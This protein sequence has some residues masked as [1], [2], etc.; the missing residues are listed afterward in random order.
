[1][2][3][4]L[5]QI[6]NKAGLKLAIALLRDPDREVRRLAI[7]AVGRIGGLEVSGLVTPY[8]DDQ[9]LDVREQ[10]A[11]ALALMKDR[12]TTE[13]LITKAKLQDPAQ[14]SYVYALYRLADER[15]IPVMHEIL[16]NPSASPS[17]GDPS[18]LL[19]AL[20]A[21]W[22]MKQRLSA[23]ELET[24]LSHADPRVR[25]NA[26]DV[27]TASPE[28]SDCDALRKH[29]DAM[30]VIVRWK[31]LETSAAAGCADLIEKALKDSNITLR[32]QAL[33][34]IAKLKKNDALA[35]LSEASQDRS[36]IIRWRS[37][38]AVRELDE[39]V[40]S[41][42]LETLRKNSDSAVRLA[43]LDSLSALMPKTAEI[44]KPYLKS[45]DFAERATA[46]DALGKTKKPEY[47]SDLI[48]AYKISDDPTEIEGR[49]SVLD[50][51]G[52]YNY[53]D[54]VAVLREA[55]WDPE[56]TVRRHAIDSLKKLVGPEIYSEG[57]VTNLEDFA[58][59]AANLSFKTLTNYPKDFGHPVEDSMAEMTLTKGTVVIRLLGREAP[60]HVLNFKKLAEKGV[61]NGLRIHRVVPN[62]VIQGGDPRGDGWGGAGENIHDQFN[63]IPY[64]RGAVGMPTAGKD[65]GGSQ[66]FIT[67][68]RQP[69][70]DGNYTVFGEV[71][72]GMEF[73]DSTEIGD[74]I[75]KVQIKPSPNSTKARR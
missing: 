74:S 48:G 46:A 54:S 61:Y 65:T 22:S 64:K 36:W 37:A 25:I 38:E 71:I 73:V 40:A 47:L 67:M 60:I 17:T 8:L 49:I 4:A 44:L 69:H 62:F 34:A 41:P 57:K 10:A 58:G 24:M 23:D 31:A 29:Y 9:N 63:R 19:F 14:W 13:K 15:A 51:L 5:G 16:K 68:S 35:L 70:L 28:K 6:R 33:V 27:L 30:P 20:K 66:F 7:E 11:L 3:F 12:A 50:V 32:G 56:S 72:S 2:A 55:L 18:S 43:A 45:S 42:L 59:R 75:V 39:N 52:D 26:L 1:V 21:L 53:A